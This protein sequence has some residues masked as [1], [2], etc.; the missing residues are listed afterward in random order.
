[1]PNKLGV[2]FVCTANICRSPTAEGVFRH[3]AERAGLAEHLLI[4]SAG[5]HDFHLGA[6]PDPRAQLAA[7]NRGYD[8]SV[9][10][11]RQV[12]RAD[13]EKFDYILAMDIKNM[14]ALHRLG[15]PDLWHKPKLL[16]SYSRTYTEKQLADPYA[17][18]QRDFER[19]LDMIESATDGLLMKIKADMQHG[20]AA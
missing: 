19:V 14:T 17:G 20:A 15:E 8:L 18:D 13:L 1:M 7:S 9:L 10:C 16:M 11:A 3:K 5:T 6:P 12:T 4:D 2:L